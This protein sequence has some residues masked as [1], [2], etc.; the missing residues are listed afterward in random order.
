MV[1]NFS[2]VQ[3][4]SKKTIWVSSSHT[5]ITIISSIY[6]SSLI[7]F[8]QSIEPTV[9]LVVVLGP[10]EGMQKLSSIVNAQLNVIY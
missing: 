5:V 4:A 10:D 3:P 9:R 1:T 6:L 2:D 8:R 7:S